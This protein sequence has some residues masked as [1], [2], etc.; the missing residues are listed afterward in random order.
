MN[1][2]YKPTPR[3]YVSTHVDVPWEFLQGAA[4][5]KQVQ[6]DK[7][8]A[9]V[10]AAA[11]LLDFENIPG[12][13]QWKAE[14]QKYYNEQ[15]IQVRDHLHS[16][17]D[18]SGASRALTG[19]VRDIVQ[20]KDVAVMKAAVEPYKEQ[21]KSWQ[22]MKEDDKFLY[23]WQEKFN[24][25]YSTR[26]TKTGKHNPYNQSVGYEAPDYYK[27]NNETFGTLHIDDVTKGGYFIDNNGM[28]VTA[29]TG[30]GEI[31]PENIMARA[32]QAIVNY[33]YTKSYKDARNQAEAEGLTKQE[34]IT[35]RADEIGIAKLYHHGLDQ[36]RTVW[37]NT[38]DASYMGDGYMKRFAIN[39]NDYIPLE[40][41]DLFNFKEEE[42]QFTPKEKFGSAYMPMPSK[43]AIDEN[44]ELKAEYD[45]FVKANQVDTPFSE[46]TIE[47]KQIAQKYF[48]SKGDDY[49]ALKNKYVSGKTTPQ[50]VSLINSQI[51]NYKKQFFAAAK[52]NLLGRTMADIGVTAH[53]YVGY[54]PGPDGSFNASLLK[55]GSGF[56]TGQ[57]K[58][59]NEGNG[60]G[61]LLKD[62]D[63]EDGDKALINKEYSPASPYYTISGGDAKFAAPRQLVITDEEGNVKGRYAMPVTNPNTEINRS[64]TSIAKN[65]SALYTPNNF[66]QSHAADYKIKYVPFN[67]TTN[68]PLTNDE[69][70]GMRNAGIAMAATYDVYKDGKL[71]LQTYTPEAVTLEIEKLVQK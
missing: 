52:Q 31:N 35:K 69:I 23:P 53:E 44:P 1:R 21:L 17:G 9:G 24:P 27:D 2:F 66:V 4:D 40:A 61:L 70:I 22:K 6:Y 11:K 3:E 48:D 39:N 56:L 65:A 26:D 38:S 68:K 37:K 19:V 55:S 41:K 50:E 10:D 7:A 63:I 8:D 34:D 5:K 46:L 64:Y 30:G 32:Q 58:I 25:M 16:T 62:L 13:N 12:D 71:V 42:D 47:N 20:D 33:R 14:K 57:T 29:V 49:K 51:L 15:L 59:Y 67:P 45:A 54:D 43:E 28:K 60:E 18:I 36:I